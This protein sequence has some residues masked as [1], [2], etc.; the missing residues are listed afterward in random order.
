VDILAISPHPDDVEIGCSGFILKAKQIGRES[1]IVIVTNGQSGLYGEPEMRRKESFFASKLL[2]GKEPIF[3]NEN[4][5]LVENNMNLRKKISNIIRQFKPKLVI[6]PFIKDKHPDHIAVSS[7]VRD[8]L[9]M[10][11]SNLRE[12]ENEKYDV[13][14]HLEMIMDPL[15]SD[16][17]E[18]I[19]DI[20]E[21][22]D[23]K[24]KVLSMHSSQQPIIDS[25]MNFE[26]IFSTSFGLKHCEI[27]NVKKSVLKNIDSFF[28][29]IKV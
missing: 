11:R 26:R 6:S 29:E 27:F 5:G 3:L 24:E 9:F 8:S 16:T 15:S 2:T 19:L 17:Y 14:V 4:D 25:Y 12:L 7:A 10:S 1:Q 21:V 13:P 20:S 23:E 22:W 18:I 28:G